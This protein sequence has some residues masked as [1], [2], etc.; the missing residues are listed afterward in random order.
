MPDEPEAI[1]LV[2]LMLLTSPAVL[3]QQQL[4]TMVRLAT[5]PLSLDPTL[6]TK[7][8]SSCALAFAATSRT[9]PDPGSDSR[10]HAA[11]ATAEATDW[12]QIIALYDQLYALRPHPVVA[13]N[14]SVAVA[15]LHGPAEGLPRSP[16]STPPRSTSTSH[17][18]PPAP[19]FSHEQVAATST[20]RVRPSHRTH[21]E[22][23]RTR[24]SS[25]ANGP[26]S[27]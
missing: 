21:Y 13:L 3:P 10:V 18:M 20:R 2:A 4:R 25:C 6:I 27:E 7:A 11:A 14:R 5:R 17:T 9:V 22:R 8:T 12:S 24:P 1:G 26:P 15:E 19:T 16:R 23:G